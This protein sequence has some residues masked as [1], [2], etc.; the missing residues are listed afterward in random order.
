MISRVT[1]IFAIAIAVSAVPSSEHVPASE[2]IEA[3]EHAEAQAQ[4]NALLAAGKS[5]SACKQLAVA[6]VKN[7]EENVKEQQKILNKLPTGKNCKNEGQE[8]VKKA[9]KRKTAAD[10][11]LKKAK[12]KVNQALQADITVKT[13][14]GKAKEKKCVVAKTDPKYK[15]AKQKF[16]KATTAA[17]TKSGEAEAAQKG[18]DD[19]KAAAKKEMNECLCKTKK[20]S[21]CSMESSYQRQC[22]GPRGV[23]EGKE[24]AM[25]PRWRSGQQMQETPS[26]QGQATFDEERCQESQLSRQQ[27]DSQSRLQDGSMGQ[28]EWKRV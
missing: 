14:Y 10:K 22:R 19:A 18:V 11:A 12:K 2:M 1:L 16:D 28:K 15:A 5:D 20:E 8:A 17:T 24:H 21:C 23:P 7:I 6:E 3:S 26:S 27:E 9:E 4:V 13:T 25:R